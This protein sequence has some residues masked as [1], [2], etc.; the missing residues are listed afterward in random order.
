MIAQPS[1]T[2]KLPAK[3]KPLIAK[4]KRYIFLTLRLLS[5]NLRKGKKLLRI[6]GVLSICMP[7]VGPEFKVMLYLRVGLDLVKYIL[8]FGWS[9]AIFDYRGSGVSEG[10]YT[11]MGVN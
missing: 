1:N 6:K 3:I 10:E 4:A 8:P 5:P 2:S 11:S 9:M 7:I